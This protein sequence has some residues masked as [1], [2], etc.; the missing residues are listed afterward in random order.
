MGWLIHAAVFVAVNAFLWLRALGTD[1][2]TPV[3]M[4]SGWAMALCIHGVVV[5]AADWG[6]AVHGRMLEAERRRMGL[7]RDPW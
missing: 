7:E 4:L 1:G 3:V 6:R 2:H 5:L